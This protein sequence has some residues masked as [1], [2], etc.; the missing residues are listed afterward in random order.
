MDYQHNVISKGEQ[1]DAP[2]QQ[3]V[4]VLASSFIDEQ[5]GQASELHLENLGNQDENDPNET[6]LTYYKLAY[7]MKPTATSE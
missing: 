5:P 3:L 6:Y 1:N 4:P 7:S 2:M